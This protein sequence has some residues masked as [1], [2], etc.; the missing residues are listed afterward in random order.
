LYVDLDGTIS[1]GIEK[2]LF[3]KCINLYRS[4]TSENHKE[5]RTCKIY[6]AGNGNSG[7]SIELY[8]KNTILKKGDFISL[9]I[10]IPK[11]ENHGIFFDLV[12]LSIFFGQEDTIVNRFVKDIRQTYIIVW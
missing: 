2:G 6:F 8:S 7:A 4:G 3:G 11:K 9:N 5:L 1:E 12:A 10:S